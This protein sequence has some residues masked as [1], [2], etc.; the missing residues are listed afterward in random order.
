MIRFCDGCGD[1]LGPMDYLYSVCMDCTKARQRAA[2]TGGMCK[3]GANKRTSPLRSSGSRK[4]YSCKRCLG[5]IKQV[6]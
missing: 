3:C 4:W 5:T 2:T 6:A 1:K